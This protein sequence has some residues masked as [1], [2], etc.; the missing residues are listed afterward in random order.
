MS[1]TRT[2][3]ST[4][5]SLAAGVLLIAD[6]KP[7]YAAVIEVISHDGA[8]LRRLQS[9]ATVVTCPDADTFYCAYY[10][11]AVTANPWEPCDQ[12]VAAAYMPLRYSGLERWSLQNGGAFLLQRQPFHERVWR[13]VVDDDHETRVITL[14]CSAPL[15]VMTT[16][17]A[18]L[19][20]AG[21]PDSELP[22]CA[23]AVSSR[24]QQLN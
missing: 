5:H 2:T 22:I 3:V 18:L 11:A 6:I 13:N 10:A 9:S 20:E 12:S 17:Q 14:E 24:L 4:D 23:E 21:V 19:R 1:A 15:D 7:R 8:E 16:I